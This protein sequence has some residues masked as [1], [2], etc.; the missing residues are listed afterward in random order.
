[1][2][3]NHLTSIT[4]LLALL[5]TIPFSGC[6]TPDS[7]E[8]VAERQMHQQWRSLTSE[9]INKSDHIVF[10]GAGLYLDGGSVGYFFTNQHGA[11]TAFLPHPG[12]D[13]KEMGIVRDQRIFL[14]QAESG[15]DGIELKPGSPLE[16]KLKTL[17]QAAKVSPSTADLHNELQKFSS[18]L[19][20]REFE[21]KQIESEE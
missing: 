13:N 8:D 3:R 2:T 20:T 9:I 11:F 18:A 14:G 4:V 15:T 1:M 21:W 7:A 16:R 19:H 12:V 6:A 10:F 5:I 17:L